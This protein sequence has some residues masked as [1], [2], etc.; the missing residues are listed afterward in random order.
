M[1]CS[2]CTRQNTRLTCATCAQTSV[3]PL[4]TE[5]LFKTAERDAAAEK[6][7][8]HIEGQG[9]AV[10]AAVAR[11]EELRERLE[12]TRRETEKMREGLRAG[13]NSH[14]LPPLP[15]ARVKDVC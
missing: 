5:I 2:I 1:Q 8:E 9:G 12:R 11:A 14:S 13:I 6:V 10:D 4:R 3:W 7:Q 15:G